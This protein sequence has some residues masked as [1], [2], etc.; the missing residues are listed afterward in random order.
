M[1][2]SLIAALDLTGRKEA[3]DELHKNEVRLKEAERIAH[4][5]WWERQFSTNH[6]MLSDELCRIFG[7]QPADIPEWH[8]R[9]LNLIHPE[10]RSRVA[11]AAANAIRGGPRYDVEYRVIR[12]DGAVRM[13]HSRGDVTWDETGKPL[14]Q[15]GVLQDI[16]EL[17]LAEQE[18]RASEAR[19]RTFV[20]HATDAFFLLDDR[21]KVVDVNRQ[22]CNSLGYSREELVGLYPRDFDVGLDEASI[23]RLRQRIAA[24]EILTFE[25]R[26]RRKDDVSFPVEISATQFEPGGRLLCLVRDITER[27]RA[28]DALK[29]SEERFR[30]LVQFSFDVYWE[31]DAQHRFI[32]QEFAEGLIDAPAPGSEIGKTRWEVPYL[33][34]DEEA[35]RK[36]RETLDAHLPFR[37]FELARPTPDGEKRYVSVSGMP[38]F[39]H[40]GDFVGY[41]GVGRHITERKQ[42]ELAIRESEQRFRTLFEKADDAI[43]LENERDE[44]I[45]VN[46]RA[47]ALLGY[48]REEL[49]KMKV[50]DLQAP[51]M[52]DHA[53]S[54]MRRELERHGGDTFESVD[55]HRSGRRV[56]V[57]VTNTPIF[58]HGEKLVLSL[59][60]DITERKRTAE[61]LQQMQEQLAH[62]NRVAT[63]GQLTASIAHEIAQPI[64]AVYNRANAALNFLNRDPPDLEEV[65]EA[66]SRIGDAADRAREII[67][68]IRD[69]VKKAPPRKDMFDLNAAIEEVLLLASNT[70]TKD[71]IV[72]KSDFAKDLPSIHGDRVQLQQVALNLILNALEAMRSVDGHSRE[73]RI[74]SEARH[75]GDVLVTICDTGPG[76]APENLERVFEPFFTTKSSGVGIGLSIC[77]SI[78][79]AHGGSLRAGANQPR[80][81][82]FQFTL[83]GAPTAS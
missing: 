52:R 60:R 5:G 69:Q 68:S 15:F 17:R 36:H 13:V 50:S 6:V 40:K 14:R 48:S 70:I 67:G 58:D 27:K 41:R 75:A 45:E 20:D 57:E 21:L 26:H 65:R 55:L 82:M 8:Q 78:V 79:E 2:K 61:A 66:V 30:T 53:G 76:I 35:W 31:S 73:L 9:W 83:P 80:G 22:A 28:E 34:P 19:F 49:L 24:G 16:T 38:M 10:D 37:D 11:E 81:A 56:V 29:A 71:A 33:E 39:D 18:L 7:V 4:F 44:I 62:A 74:R 32:R 51:E 46:E 23:E 77:R 64:G 42:A 25:T 3:M 47:C 54:A 72:V 12:S 43:F 59:V 1:L 63:M